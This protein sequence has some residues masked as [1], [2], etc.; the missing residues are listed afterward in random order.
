MNVGSLFDA[1]KDLGPR[2]TL[3]GLLPAGSLALFVLALVSS[4]APDSAP[5][6]DH[7]VAKA[8]DLGGWEATLL[9]L[10]LIVATVV[11]QPLQLSLVRLLEGYWGGSRVARALALPLLEYQRRRWD[12]LDRAQ[13]VSSSDE[14]LDAEQKARVDD[15]G[16]QLRR[17]F[18]ARDRLRPTRLGNTLRAAEDRAGARYGLDA[19]TVWPRLYPI[20]PDGIRAVLEDYRNELD[21]AARFSVVFLIATG[22]GIGFLAP[23]GWWLLVPA[24]TVLLAWLSYRGAVASAVGYG[25]AIE[26][27]FDLHRFDLLQALHLP[28][29]TS[30]AAER[31]ANF[32]LC[33]FLGQGVP[34]DFVYQ[35]GSSP[36]G[37]E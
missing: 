22:I 14:E 27:A 9:F 7:V 36:S 13:A 16:W 20:L 15:A 12:A 24:V 1:A 37:S 17:F 3:V 34:V 33:E 5:N 30:R 6:L 4:G 11:F 29:P 26:T 23:Y 10:A 19:V 18:P 8:Q 25:E 21:I 32:K 2:F 28:L 35:H 31:E